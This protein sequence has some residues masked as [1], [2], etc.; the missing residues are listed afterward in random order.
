MM[1]WRVVGIAILFVLGW[2]ICKQWPRCDRV[3]TPWYGSSRGC[4]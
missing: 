4:K 2:I 1:R 3:V